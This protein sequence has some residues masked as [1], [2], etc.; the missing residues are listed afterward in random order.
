MRRRETAPWLLVSLLLC[1]KNTLPCNARMHSIGHFH[2]PTRPHQTSSRGLRFHRDLRPTR[3]AL[4]RR[5]Q[6]STDAV[7]GAYGA[8]VCFCALLFHWLGD[9][10]LALLALPSPVEI[11]PPAELWREGAAEV[12]MEKA[13]RT[14][15]TKMA[16]DIQESSRLY[17]CETGSFCGD[18]DPRARLSSSFATTS[19]CATQ[20][21]ARL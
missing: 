7:L 4:T 6:R 8:A 16:K 20:R 13:V 9:L 19:P 15:C 21:T 2:R 11:L 12:P 3:T 10:H 14:M 1:A 5:A 17:P 18:K